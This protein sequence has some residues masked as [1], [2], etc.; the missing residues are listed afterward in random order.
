MTTRETI[1]ITY[2]RDCERC[3]EEL[4]CGFL[5]LLFLPHL[6]S[7]TL[8]PTNYCGHPDPLRPH[9]PAWHDAVPDKAFEPA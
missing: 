4:E 1:T 6:A 8:T 9:A 5:S 7:L 2:N 3:Q